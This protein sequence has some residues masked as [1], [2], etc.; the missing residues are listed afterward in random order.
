M[1]RSIPYAFVVAAAFVAAFG[2]QWH[3]GRFLALRETAWVPQSETYQE[4]W[5]PRV[6]RFISL[7]HVQLVADVLWLKFLQDS[8]LA[9]VARG[10]LS[11]VFADLDLLT[12]LDPAFFEAYR[13]GAPL[14]AVVRNDIEGAA[15][16]LSKG[17][18]FAEERLPSLHEVFRERH[19]RDKH[20]VPL[21]TS[22]L[23]LFEKHDLPA[24]TRA[25]LRADAMG[26]APEY[27]GRLAA[28]LRQPGGIYEVGIR[29]LQFMA[30]QTRDPALLKRYSEQVFSLKVGAYLSE[31]TRKHQRGEWIP[32]SDPWGGRLSIKDGK[33]QTTTPRETALGVE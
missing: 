11:T 29:L 9:H 18:T 1:T 19:W 31:L 8:N 23:E 2:V 10:R 6:V 24:A 28:R 22:Y 17:E 13:S 27:V 20:L 21:I 4:K 26:G 15:R 25:F 7:G 14:L 30:S 5:D 33:V 3:V 32:D 12:D 16:I